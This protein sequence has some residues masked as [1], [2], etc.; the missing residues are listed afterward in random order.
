MKRALQFQ[1]C[2]GLPLVFSLLFAGCNKSGN[3]GGGT[4]I[5]NSSSAS[6]SSSSSSSAPSKSSSAFALHSKVGYNVQT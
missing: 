6:S 2:L 1:L 4:S 5:G 3:S